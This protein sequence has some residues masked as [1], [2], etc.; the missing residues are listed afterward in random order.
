MS[1]EIVNIKVTYND[2]TEKEIKKG[3]VTEIDKDTVNMEMLDFRKY[4]IVRLTY[5][6][7]C[8][9]QRLGLTGILKAYSDGIAL[10][11]EE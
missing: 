2:G 11:D 3:V 7:F 8:T 1:K 6:L 5:G 4:D 10:P 9:L